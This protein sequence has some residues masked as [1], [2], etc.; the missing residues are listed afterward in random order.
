MQISIPSIFSSAWSSFPGDLILLLQMTMTITKMPTA[1]VPKK[2][3]KAIIVMDNGDLLTAVSL[4][5]QKPI[6][7]ISLL[8]RF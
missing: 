5:Q 6:I 3:I 2:A 1:T 4:Q 8:M 7:Q